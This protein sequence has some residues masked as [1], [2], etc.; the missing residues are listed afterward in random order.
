MQILLPISGFQNPG[1]SLKDFLIRKL[2]PNNGESAGDY[3]KRLAIAECHFNFANATGS[4][5]ERVNA[6]R[7]DGIGAVFD[8]D[9][10]HANGVS[11]SINSTSGSGAFAQCVGEDVLARKLVEIRSGVDPGSPVPASMA[12]VPSDIP[13][14]AAA[15]A[16]IDAGVTAMLALTYTVV[17]VPPSA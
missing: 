7:A 4:L 15:K 12:L 13:A 10:A 3:L 9:A 2:P 16:Q 11:A 5:S 1:E 8:K 17:D 6:V 14:Y